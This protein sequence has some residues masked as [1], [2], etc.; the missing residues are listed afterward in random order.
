MDDVKSTFDVL[1][2]GMKNS[3][4]LLGVCISSV[5]FA[6]EPDYTLQAPSDYD[7][8]TAKT[9][10]SERIDPFSG[11]LHISYEDMRLPATGGMDIVINR[12]Y[13]NLENP[14]TRHP[15][16]TTVKGRSSLGPGWDIHFGR[17]WTYRGVRIAANDDPRACRV[18]PTNGMQD[19]SPVFELSTGSREVLLDSSWIVDDDPMNSPVPA[20]FVTKNFSW[21]SCLPESEDLEDENNMPIGGLVVTTADGKRYKFNEYGKVLIPGP[22]NQFST[23]AY[24][25]TEIMDNSGNKLIIKYRI[26]GNDYK[27]IDYVKS[28]APGASESSEGPKAV[29]DY[30]ASNYLLLSITSQDDANIKVEYEYEPFLALVESPFHLK[31]AVLPEGHIWHYTYTGIGSDGAHSIQRITSPLGIETEYEYGKFFFSV[32]PSIGFFSCPEDTCENVVVTKKTLSG[33]V[34]EAEF[35]YQYSTSFQEND[36]TKV[37]HSGYSCIQYEHEGENKNYPVGIGATNNLHRR[38][39]LVRKTV[40]DS[41]D[42]DGSILRYEVYEYDD[43]EKIKISNLHEYRPYP[44]AFS[45]S[46]WNPVLTKKIIHQNDT[47]FTSEYSNFTSSGSPERIEG[48]PP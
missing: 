6:F 31:R 26:I 35:L 38:G 9:L 20:S 21:A 8:S 25:P 48:N 24:L 42:C 32:A 33:N 43:G 18:L 30:D 41:D 39:L 3:F 16:A 1:L 40:Y 10:D 36:V 13:G 17:I 29:F 28:V 12:V 4:F 14:H 19:K 2:S 11:R 45:D 47:I 37:V 23:H 22:M 46:V 27:V 15:Y 5:T 44:Y 34:E 7:A